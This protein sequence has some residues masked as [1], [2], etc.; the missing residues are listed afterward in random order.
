MTVVTIPS[1]V[2]Y[3]NY[4]PKVMHIYHF[5]YVNIYLQRT[6]TNA[7]QRVACNTGLLFI[8]IIMIDTLKA[9]LQ[10]KIEEIMDTE[11]ASESLATCRF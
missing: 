4:S 5:F 9:S 3:L 11:I 8:N 2:E 10:S 7:K 1:S 6:N